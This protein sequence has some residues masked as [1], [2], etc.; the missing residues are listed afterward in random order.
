M[1]IAP[2]IHLPPRLALV[3][4]DECL[5]LMLHYNL[6]AIGFAVDWIARGDEAIQAFLKR[7]PALV[8]LDWMLPGIAGIEVLRQLRRNPKTRHVPVLML[9]GCASPEERRRAIACGVDVFLVKPFAVGDFLDNLKRMHP[10]ASINA[11]LAETE[12]AI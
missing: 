6:E 10:E 11:C 5:A 4:D 3:E 9:T 1:D 7:P 2:L 12:L 8:V